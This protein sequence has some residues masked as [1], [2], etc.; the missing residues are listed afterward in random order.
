MSLS[1]TS[2]KRLLFT[3]CCLHI[4][5][6]ERLSHFLILPLSLGG[7]YAWF[8]SSWCGVGVATQKQTGPLQELPATR[9]RHQP[10]SWKNQTRW[11]TGGNRFVL[12]KQR[13]RLGRMIRGGEADV[14]IS[15]GTT[16]FTAST[17]LLF[18]QPVIPG[19]VHLKNKTSLVWWCS[20]TIREGLKTIARKITSIF[21]HILL[22]QSV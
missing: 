1:V 6:L 19:P 15:I 5:L 8:S 2:Q 11:K 10:Q 12:A 21:Y 22:V 3:P 4:H 17:H 20:S 9:Q 13:K 7:V 14:S 16:D 18:W